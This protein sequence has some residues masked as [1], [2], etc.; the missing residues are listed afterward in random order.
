[1]PLSFPACIP[2]VRLKVSLE[3]CRE[4]KAVRR[5]FSDRPAEFSSILSA[6]AFR[7]KTLRDSVLSIMTYREEKVN[8]HFCG[9]GC[10]FDFI[11]MI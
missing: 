10:C 6:K 3:R 9:K 5:P 2:G 1:M 4:I 11:C 8:G 7:R